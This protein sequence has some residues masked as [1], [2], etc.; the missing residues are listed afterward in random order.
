MICHYI[1]LFL[2]AVLGG[3]LGGLMVHIV[4]SLIQDRKLRRWVDKENKWHKDIKWKQLTDEEIMS[5]I[6]KLHRDN[7]ID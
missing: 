3:A 6:D 4:W 2:I 5:L 1:T 7:K